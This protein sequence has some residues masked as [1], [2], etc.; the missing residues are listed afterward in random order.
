[1][2]VKDKFDIAFR[3]DTAHD[4]HGVVTKSVGLLPSNHYL[5]VCIDY[6]FGNRPGW[7]A[8]AA[9]GKTVVSSSMIDRVAAKH[10]RR[11]QEGPVGFK[12]FVDGLLAGA[13]GLPG[14]ESARAWRVRR[15]GT[16]V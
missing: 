10:G 8:D 2:L 1:M 4:R 11:V 13:R 16:A 6:L 9:V 15:D 5:S 7:R 12:W 3:C 14:G